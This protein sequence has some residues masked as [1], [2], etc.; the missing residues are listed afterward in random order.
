ML[1]LDDRIAVQRL[2]APLRIGDALDRS[3]EQYVKRVTTNVFPGKL[4]FHLEAT[5]PVLR[6]AAAAYLKGDLAREL[7]QRDLIFRAGPHVF[8]PP[9]SRTTTGPSIVED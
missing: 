6:E 8:A 4:I 9:V 1:S 5:A 7:F 2:A 3:H